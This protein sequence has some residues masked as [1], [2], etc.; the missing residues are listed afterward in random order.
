MQPSSLS[1]YEAIEQASVG[2]LD[3]ARVG[4]WEQV[5]GFEKDCVLLL[6]QLQDGLRNNP[7]SPQEEQKK[8]I[9]MQHI[10][11][12]DAEIRALAQPY[13]EDLH[14]T[15]PINSQTLH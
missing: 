15:L 3:A 13:L 4:N 8:A 9:I 10:L 12:N 11:R 7:L 1:Y 6:R 14:R 5:I 2:M